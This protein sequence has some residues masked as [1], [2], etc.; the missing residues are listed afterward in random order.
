[1]FGL[2]AGRAQTR[3]R[4]ADKLDIKPTMARFVCAVLVLYFGGLSWRF[5][6]D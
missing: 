5:G 4:L 1:M 2:T 6:E 3:H